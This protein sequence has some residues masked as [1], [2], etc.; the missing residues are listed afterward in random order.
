M[1]LLLISCAALDF[2]AAP[3]PTPTATETPLPSPTIVWF[4]PSITPSVQAFATNTPLPDMR[5]GL[6]EVLDEDDFSNEKLWDIAKS[7]EGSSALNDGNLTLAVQPGVYLISLRHELTLSNFYAEITASPNLCRN[8]D[9]YGFLVRANAVAYYRFS[10]TC[11]QKMSAERISV[12]TRE[13][14][15]SP[16]S[17]GDAPPGAPGQVRIGVWAVGREMRLFLNDRY[18]FTIVNANYPTGTVGVF[19]HSVGQNATVVNF[20]DLQIR[21]VDY[22]PPTRTPKP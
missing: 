16:I 4:P 14:L 11:E 21:E 10:L 3:L 17:T 7:D 19:V 1:T 20:S 8:G 22:T 5:P 2:A 13:V 6:G 15:Q 18:Q 12:G 9:S